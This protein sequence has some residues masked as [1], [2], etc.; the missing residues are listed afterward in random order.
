MHGSGFREAIAPIGLVIDKVEYAADQILITGRSRF[1]VSICPNCCRPS[2][3]V[4]SRY[5]RTLADLPSHGRPVRITLVA[6]RF[7]C[8]T[9]RCTTRIFVERFPP[10]VTATFARR[11]TRLDSIVHHLGLALGGRPAAS[12]ARR[13]LMPVSKDTLL[14]T[15]RRRFKGA[16]VK[17]TIIGIDDWAWK[18]GQRYGTIVCDLERRQIIDLLP[19]RGVATVEAWLKA[20]PEICIISRDR[21]GGYRHAA[22]RALPDA[23]QIADRWHLMENA[24]QAFLDAVR[25]SMRAIRQALQSAEPDPELLTCAERLQYEGFK[26]RQDADDAIRVLL[27]K[28]A[29]IKA[30]VRA[31]G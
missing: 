24:S 15:V 28:G 21:G 13:L 1:R 14:R 25:K 26:R 9:S 18:R 19:D 20:R 23:L 8:A 4:H 29:S 10:D 2:A 30:V 27:G 11:T 17:P 22:A 12:L 3:R 16:Q 6:R 7:R 31:T 5:H